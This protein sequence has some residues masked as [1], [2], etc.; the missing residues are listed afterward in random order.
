MNHH[1]GWVRPI[2][3]L[4]AVWCA[5]TMPGRAQDNRTLSLM[6]VPASVQL[7][8]GQFLIGPTLKI[9]LQGHSDPRI[10]R[11][12]DRFVQDLSRRTGIPVRNQDDSN[13][14]II[15]ACGGAG[16]KVQ[17]LGEDESYRLEVTASGAR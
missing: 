3:L 17:A 9:S 8:A 13:A 4:L 14:T 1:K 7:G 15:V 2:G 6:P 10:E 5:L 11:A 12:V 16:S